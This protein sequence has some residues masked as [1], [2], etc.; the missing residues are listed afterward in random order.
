METVDIRNL[1]P[2]TEIENVTKLFETDCDR[3]TLNIKYQQ[4]FIDF[5][6]NEGLDRIPIED[7]DTMRN[8][9]HQF[10]DSKLNRVFIVW[11]K[12][13]SF[14]LTYQGDGNDFLYIGFIAYVL[15]YINFEYALILSKA[16]ESDIQYNAKH[17]KSRITFY[18]V[19]SRYH[20]FN[21]VSQLDNIVKSKDDIIGNL[22]QGCFTNPF[23]KLFKRHKKTSAD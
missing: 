14:V 1:R 10:I 8:L 16:I 21:I 5:I 7:T 11:L 20:R 3:K 9:I 4:E 13:K 23:G 12:M 19:I 15:N 18:D 22:S 6:S 17:S 2:T